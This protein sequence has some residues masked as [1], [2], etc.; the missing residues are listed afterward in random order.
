MKIKIKLQSIYDYIELELLT[1][2]K[3][4]KIAKKQFQNQ[5]VPLA[6]VKGTTI[7]Y[8]QNRIKQIPLFVHQIIHSVSYIMQNKGIKDQQFLCYTVQY[9]LQ[10][11]MKKLKLQIK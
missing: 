1:Q 10:Q 6:Y 5:Q 4:N 2:Q 9:C 11:I 7:Y 3:Y 8:P